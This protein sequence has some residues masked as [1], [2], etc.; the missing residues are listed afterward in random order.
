MRD[1]GICGLPETASRP[2][3]SHREQ[4]ISELQLLRVMSRPN[5]GCAPTRITDTARSSQ[6]RIAL[7]A[8]S[9]IWKSSFKKTLE[10][11]R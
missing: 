2:T 4:A 1:A 11:T 5:A 7:L 6:A 3:S 10:N 9:Y 8:S